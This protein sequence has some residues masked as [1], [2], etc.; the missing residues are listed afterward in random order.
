MRQHETNVI[1]CYCA[2]A[3]VPAAVAAVVVV[4]WLHVRKIECG[5][6]LLLYAVSLLLTSRSQRRRRT[7]CVAFEQIHFYIYCIVYD[8]C[9]CPASWT[10][11]V[12]TN[13]SSSS[14]SLSASPAVA[15]MNL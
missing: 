5:K 9:M 11:Y 12:L 13:M 10:L 8:I 3:A 1:E 2:A 4:V 14:S 15:L 6:I 7:I